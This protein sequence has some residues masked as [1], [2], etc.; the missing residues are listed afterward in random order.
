MPDLPSPYEMRDWKDVAIKYDEFI[1]S[2]TKTGQYLPLAG[3]KSSGVNY[4]SLKPILLQTYVGGS[5]SAA[6]G[7]NIMPSIVGA[8]LVG[9][10]KSNQN[11]VNWTEKVKDFFNKSNGQ[12]IY[13][14]NYSATSGSDWW[15]DVMPNVFFYQLYTQYPSTPDFETQLTTIADRWLE[16]VNK[17]G[18]SSTPWTVPNMNYR[19]W[20]LSSMTGNTESVMEPESAGSIGWLLYHAYLKTG[21]KKYLDGAQMSIEFLSNWNSNPSYELQLPY[22]T[23]IAAKMNAEQGTNY[24]IDKM[25][26]WSFNRGDLRGW[27]TIKGTWDGKDVSGLVG[28]ANDSGNDYAFF[29]NG[30]HQAA[31]LVPLVKYDKRYAKAIAKWTLNLANASRL[32]YSKYLPSDR[33]DDYV[34]SS[35]YDPQSVIAYEALKE[36]NNYAGN[37]P[38]Y[39]TGDAKRGGWASTNLGLYGS[40]SVGYLGAIVETTNVSGI[41]KLDVNK[42]DFFGQNKFPTYLIYNPL[43]TSQQV[44]LELGSGTYDVYDALS[45]TVILSGASGNTQ[46]EVKTKEAVLLSYL[47]AGSSTTVKD[48]KLYLQNDVVDFHYGYNFT[49]ALRIKSLTTA[50]AFAEYNKQVNVYSEVDNETVPVVYEW[51]VNDVFAQTTSVNTF[52][53]T[54]PSV[55]GDYKIVLK[56]TSGTLSAKDSVTVA[57]MEKIPASPVITTISQDK[58]YYL[59]NTIAQLICHVPIAKEMDLTYTWTIAS[60]TKVTTDSLLLWTLPSEEGLYTATCTVKNKLNVEI[61]K[62]LNL[63]VKKSATGTTAAFAYYPM[64]GDVKDYSGNNYN[65]QRVGASPTEDARESAQSAYRFATAGDIIFISNQ[66]SLNFQQA[67]VLSFWVKPTEVNQESFILSHGSWE[68]RWKVSLIPDRRIRWTTKTTNATIDLDSSTPLELNRFYHVAVT[69]TG[70]S[71]EIY[72]NG[73]LDNYVEQRGQ[74]LTTSKAISFGQKSQSETAYPLIGTLD[75]VRIYNQTLTPDEI[76]TFKSLWN[77]E[78]VTGLENNPLNNIIA[79]PNP[80]TD[81]SFYIQQKETGAVLEL[82]DPAGKKIPFHSSSDGKYTHIQTEQN[83]KGIFLLRIKNQQEIVTKKIVLY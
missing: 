3:L 75:E 46:V 66:S 12:H 40:S 10:N 82:I 79:F 14:N 5:T 18:G 32:F 59:A 36:K 54:T 43:S 58:K 80:S 45:E 37:L 63:L 21:N 41:L 55:A 77:S 72:I 2:S 50:S 1:F 6:E 42:T 26:N 23:F 11:G 74:L 33:Q 13:L 67:I 71:M 51:Y 28:E 9:I 4:P 76:A 24:N 70:Y 22:G 17:M 73:E 19:G 56:A 65:A 31:A 64:D 53:W 7:I 38:L 34:W 78:I 81:G 8:S 39:G 29:L 30:M 68:E 52:S 83:Y 49:P 60:G 69:F 44:T 20:Y 35:T 16:A 57:V 15:Y 47:P 27:G 61:T 48:G 25:L 62:S